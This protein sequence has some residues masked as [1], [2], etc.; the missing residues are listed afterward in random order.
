MSAHKIL[1]FVGLLAIASY[2]AYPTDPTQL[3]DFCVGVNHPHDAG[4]NV[5]F[6]PI[7]YLQYTD[8]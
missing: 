5:S 7:V 1:T 6:L 2:V 3:Q 4:N 8:I